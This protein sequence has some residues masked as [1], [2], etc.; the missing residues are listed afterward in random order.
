MREN[1]LEDPAEGGEGAGCPS[2][3]PLQASNLGPSGFAL[4]LPSRGGVCIY[5]NFKVFTEYPLNLGLAV[6]HVFRKPDL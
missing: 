6:F 3:G 5:S 4:C 2:L 1:P